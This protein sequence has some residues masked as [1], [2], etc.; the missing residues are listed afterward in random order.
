MSTPDE[1]GRYTPG[2]PKPPNY[3]V[4]EPVICTDCGYWIEPLSIFPGNRCQL[5]HANDPHVIAELERMTSDDLARLWG[6]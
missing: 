3:G 6:G 1:Y 5:C 2:S 4:N